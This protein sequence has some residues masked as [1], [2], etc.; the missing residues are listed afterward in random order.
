MK[1]TT[2]SCL[3]FSNFAILFS[4]PDNPVTQNFKSALHY[5]NHPL[6]TEYF[7]VNAINFVAINSAFEI[8]QS[9]L[10]DGT[11]PL[12]CLQVLI[13]RFHQHLTIFTQVTH[14]IN[15]PSQTNPL[16][17]DFSY[18]LSSRLLPLLHFP[19]LKNNLSKGNWIMNLSSSNFGKYTLWIWAVLH[20]SAPSQC[21]AWSGYLP[22]NFEGSPS[23]LLLTLHAA[24]LYL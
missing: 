3:H 1:T 10:Y 17:H 22:V 16:L 13:L 11:D 6:C 2:A 4:S 20:F 15:P 21:P 12:W 5:L 7:D 23:T 19:H 18:S 14:S 24:I 9:F 8:T